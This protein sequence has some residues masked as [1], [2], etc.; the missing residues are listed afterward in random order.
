MALTL[1]AREKI[2]RMVE[3]GE[4]KG[5]GYIPDP[6]YEGREGFEIVLDL[7]EHHC[8]ELLDRL[9]SGEE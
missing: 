8:A 6:Y 7:L 5:Y 4:K 9:E 1:Q 2:R 3:F